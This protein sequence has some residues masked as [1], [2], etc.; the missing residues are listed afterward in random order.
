M[1]K[2]FSG[3]LFILVIYGKSNPVSGRIADIKKGRIIRCILS[4]P[5]FLIRICYRIG[6]VI[7]YSEL[8]KVPNVPVITL[9]LLDP[10]PDKKLH[11]SSP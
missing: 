7:L 9:R 1:K 4:E 3:N 11:I 10:D 5:L 8:D 2:K 6:T